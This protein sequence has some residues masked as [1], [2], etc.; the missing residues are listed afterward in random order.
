MLLSMSSTCIK[1]IYCYTRLSLNV[2]KML[3]C[4]VETL[5]KVEHNS[6]LT[7]SQTFVVASGCTKVYMTRMFL[8]PPQSKAHDCSD[9]EADRLTRRSPWYVFAKYMNWSLVRFGVRGKS[10][11]KWKRCLNHR[12]MCGNLLAVAA[13]VIAVPWHEGFCCCCY[14]PI[15]VVS[16]NATGKNMARPPLKR[17]VSSAAWVD[18]EE[19]SVMMKG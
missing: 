8:S 16:R 3:D 19:P 17:F 10:V 13:P 7:K 18:T 9:A 2:C 6:K 15:M 11:P 1:W 14:A 4:S 5:F 12:I